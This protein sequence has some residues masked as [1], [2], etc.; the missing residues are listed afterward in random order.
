MDNRIDNED[1]MQLMEWGRLLE[2]I[3]D[4]LNNAIEESAQAQSQVPVV[5]AVVDKLKNKKGVLE[6]RIRGLK[7]KINTM[8]R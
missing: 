4:D 8:P 1:V 2:S 7:I 5:K 3:T 6:E